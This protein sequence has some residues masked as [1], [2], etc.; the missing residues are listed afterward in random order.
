MQLKYVP[1][2]LL[3]V[4]V[5]CF[6]IGEGGRLERDIQFVGL[7]AVIGM[8]LAGMAMHKLVAKC[9]A[10]T[11]VLLAA[12]AF[13]LLGDQ[14]YKA[15]YSD[16]L[17]GS[18]RLHWSLAKYHVENGRYPDS[19]DRLNVVL[20]CGRATRASLLR[21]KRIGD[22]YQLLLN[23]YVPQPAARISTQKAYAAR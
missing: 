4:A 3:V 18:E 5:T 15:A 16:C 9:A 10:A 21:Y 14:S 17:A 6:F 12:I 2:L 23:A 13:S 11:G 22:G 19:L 20:P 1:L 7:I 8:P